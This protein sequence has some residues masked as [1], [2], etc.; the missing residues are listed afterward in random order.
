MGRNAGD[1]DV[2]GARA[3]RYGEYT[4]AVAEAMLVPEVG[5]GSTPA[6]RMMSSVVP[7]LVSVAL[8]LEPVKSTTLLALL[9]CIL[10]TCPW[11]RRG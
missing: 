4:A 9:P 3:F 8:L 2:S 10:M 1:G 11:R 7:K 5:A 6:P